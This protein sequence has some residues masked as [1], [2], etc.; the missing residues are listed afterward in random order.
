MRFFFR[1]VKPPY[2]PLAHRCFHYVMSLATNLT[3]FWDWRPFLVLPKPWR[4]PDLYSQLLYYFAFALDGQVDWLASRKCMMITSIAWRISDFVNLQT[5]VQRLA[6][7]PDYVEGYTVHC[8]LS[9]LNLI[10]C[11]SCHHI[12]LYG[13]GFSDCQSKDDNGKR[14]C[15][16][17]A[18]GSGCSDIVVSKYNK[19]LTYSS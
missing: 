1:W 7:N 14:W 12:G 16:V 11:R 5:T 6:G 18:E 8:L 13:Q 2:S 19:K 15:Y 10:L 3:F 9:I 17:A 4:L